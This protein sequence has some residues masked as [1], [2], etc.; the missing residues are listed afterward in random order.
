MTSLKPGFGEMA[1][2]G[3]KNHLQGKNPSPSFM[4]LSQ[5]KGGKVPHNK[6]NGGEETL[7]I[8]LHC[9]YGLQVDHFIN[10]FW[11]AL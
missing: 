6:M 2:Y 4:L 8:V 11:Y 5:E 9:V 3:S 10:I 7:S 1:R